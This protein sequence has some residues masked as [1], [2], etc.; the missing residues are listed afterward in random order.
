MAEQSRS[1][2]NE[3]SLALAELTTRS[4]LVE[5]LCKYQQ[6]ADMLA[7]VRWVKQSLKD[8][9]KVEKVGAEQVISAFRA[10]DDPDHMV[11]IEECKRFMEGLKYL[12]EFHRKKEY[13]EEA[14]KLKQEE[15]L[16]TL[17][18]TGKSQR[19]FESLHKLA[20]L[21]STSGQQ[22]EA[23]ETL[24]HMEKS[25]QS[26]GHPLSTR[27]WN[28]YGH[29]CFQFGK[30]EEA[31]KSFEVL[32]QLD[33]QLGKNDSII[34]GDLRNCVAISVRLGRYKHAAKKQAELITVLRASGSSNENLATEISLLAEYYEKMNN[35]EEAAEAYKASLSLFVSEKIYDRIALESFKI[36]RCLV[37]KHLMSEAMEYFSAALQLYEK[38]GSGYMELMAPVLENMGMI[39]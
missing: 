19:Y 23:L 36:G 7:A 35:C 22:K 10:A 34:L 29:M 30:F 25:A 31:L 14:I 17:A 2:Q 26:E 15:V 3:L 8:G 38:L 1:S 13:Y 32:L 11:A 24:S 27:F 33:R 39:L 21:L 9:N 37:Q 16:V 4:E 6:G 28:A 5:E 20:N 12:A 18:I